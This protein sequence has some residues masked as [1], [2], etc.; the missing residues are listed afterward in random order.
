MTTLGSIFSKYKAVVVFDTETSGLDFDNDQIIELA[1]MRVEAG[2][3]SLKI[4]ERM[5]AFIKLP[6]GKTL[7][8]NITELTGITNE[9]LR[10]QGI[11]SEKAA[12]MFAAMLQTGPTLMAAHNAQFDLQFTNRLLRGHRIGPVDFLDTL[13]VYKDRRA[14]P[15]KLANAILSYGLQGKVQNSHRA[16]DDVAALLEVMRAMT[17]ERDD[18]LTYVNLFGYNPKYGVSGGE[19]RR[20][21]YRPQKFRDFMAPAGMTFPE[22]ENYTPEILKTEGRPNP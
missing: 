7:P 8:E 1:A 6:D 5:D 19:L 15:H 11:S 22:I 18:L 3:S 16:I 12:G 21:T 20:V 9:V 4:T 2:T 10:D 17:K 13:T 14:Y